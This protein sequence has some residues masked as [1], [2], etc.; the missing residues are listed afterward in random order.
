MWIPNLAYMK[1]Y[2]LNSNT[3][4]ISYII[5]TQIIIY[6]TLSEHQFYQ[7]YLPPLLQGKTESG[8]F[9]FL[10][11]GSP[12]PKSFS[13]LVFRIY[14]RA[15]C[16]LNKYSTLGLHLPHIFPEPYHFNI[17]GDCNHQQSNIQIMLNLMFSGYYCLYMAWMCLPK[18]AGKLAISMLV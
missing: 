18:I 10:S 8:L 17:S 3:T 13:L 4:F 14:V 6:L 16:I 9:P 12:N 1:Q 11:P 7:L 5:W 15:L 2:F